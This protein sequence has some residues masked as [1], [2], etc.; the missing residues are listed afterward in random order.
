MV[1]LPNMEM[2]RRVFSSGESPEL[3]SWLVTTS[4]NYMIMNMLVFNDHNNYYN[5]EYQASLM[6]AEPGSGPSE[7]GDGGASR[8]RQI[9]ML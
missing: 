3:S 4:L 2:R 6:M 5:D 1:S 7:V 9:S 8:L